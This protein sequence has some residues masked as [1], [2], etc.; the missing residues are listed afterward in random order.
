MNV[1]AVLGTVFNYYLVGREIQGG[2]LPF[3]ERNSLRKAVMDESNMFSWGS[4]NSATVGQVEKSLDRLIVLEGIIDLPPSNYD[5]IERIFQDGNQLIIHDLELGVGDRVLVAVDGDLKFDMGKVYAITG[6]TGCGK[7]SFLSKIKG[8][9][10]N[11]IYGKGGIIYPK[12]NNKYPKIVML[13]Q[14]DYFPPNYSLKEILFYPDKFSGDL[15]ASTRLIEEM[16]L[17]LDL[18]SKKNWYMRLSGG[19]KK[20]VLIISAILK[21]PDI[22]ILDEVF[23]GLDT[24]SIK[25]ARQML[26]K[27]LPS[28]LIFVVD[29]HAR[30]DNNNFYDKEVH[31]A[32][33]KI[34]L[35]DIVF[36]G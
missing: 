19:E 15:E 27:Y 32:D 6:N 2:R 33:E 20:K 28:S 5:L 9:K 31:F 25:L 35:R 13:S 22:L 8:I 1:D 24:D 16:G 7:T 11:G 23:N 18:D 21:K 4:R 10:E 34:V 29:H 14:Q 30:E 17:T 3:D 12:I 36:Q 26:R